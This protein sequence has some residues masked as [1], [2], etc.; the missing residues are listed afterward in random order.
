MIGFDPKSEEFFSSTPIPS[1]GGTVRHMVYHQP[2]R[3]IW[4]GTDTNTIGRA[5]IP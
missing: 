3:E 1:G 5:R 4:F 2:T